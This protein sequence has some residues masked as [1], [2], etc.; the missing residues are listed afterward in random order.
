MVEIG[1][2]TQNVNGLDGEGD[3]D[4]EGEWVGR[5]WIYDYHRS[6]ILMEN[7]FYR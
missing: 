7:R 1:I 5:W 2:R 6:T 4:G 3:N